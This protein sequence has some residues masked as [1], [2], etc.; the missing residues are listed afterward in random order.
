[1]QTVKTLEK[2]FGAYDICYIIICYVR[3][4]CFSVLQ[5]VIYHYSYS[6]K[7]TLLH[8]IFFVSSFQIHV[9]SI[10]P[11]YVSET[12]RSA[13]LPTPEKCLCYIQ[14]AYELAMKWY[15]RMPM[16]TMTRILWQQK[17][18]LLTKY[19]DVCLCRYHSCGE[20]VMVFA[21]LLYCCIC[22]I[23]II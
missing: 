10:S 16:P 9:Q 13:K 3:S 8:M 19:V 20:Y 1:M 6:N 14:F 17:M 4:G 22:Y 23:Q 2:L 7:H 15:A 12:E 5:F 11:I 18:C 21:I